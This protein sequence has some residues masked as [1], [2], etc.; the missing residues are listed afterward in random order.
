VIFDDDRASNRR[1]VARLPHGDADRVGA[2]E[3]SSIRPGLPVWSTIHATFVP[4][5]GHRTPGVKTGPAELHEA[6]E[7]K[8]RR[9]STPNLKAQVL[10]FHARGAVAAAIAD[11]LDVADRRV[12][13]IIAAAA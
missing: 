5:I 9:R 8:R 2:A 4:L 7:Q 6:I 11:T 10:E 1:L 13:E 3:K 12:N